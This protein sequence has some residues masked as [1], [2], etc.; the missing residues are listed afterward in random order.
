VKVSCLCWLSLYYLLWCGCQ[1]REGA[2]WAS[3]PRGPSLGVLIRLRSGE[4]LCH[5]GFTLW[6]GHFMMND[7]QA[8]RSKDSQPISFSPGSPNNF[9][10][11]FLGRVE[12][13]S[14]ESSLLTPRVQFYRNRDLH[15]LTNRSQKSYSTDCNSLDKFP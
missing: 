15:A 3:V 4:H 7:W 5:R 1:V 8:E 9:T 11:M 13:T 6:N 2:P 10:E 14:T 12:V